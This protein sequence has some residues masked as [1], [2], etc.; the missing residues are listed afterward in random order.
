MAVLAYSDGG[1]GL[2]NLE[3]GKALRVL[4]KPHNSCASAVCFRDDSTFLVSEGSILS[5]WRIS[6]SLGIRLTVQDSEMF[7]SID[8]I[9]G[10]FVPRLFNFVSSSGKSGSHCL[11]PRFSECFG[12]GTGSG[13]L[14]GWAGTNGGFTASVEI[15]G[16]L[17]ACGFD[18]ADPSLLRFAVCVGSEL[19]VYSVNEN[20]SVSVIW[21]V[22]V[23][24]PC[25]HLCFMSS[26]VILGLG[27]DLRGWVVAAGGSA[28]IPEVV[29]PG[30]GVFIGGQYSFRLGSEV[31]LEVGLQTFGARMDQ[32]RE[33][34]DGSGFDR[35]IDLCRRVIGNDAIATIGLPT[36]ASQRAL[37]IERELA[38]LLQNETERR[39]NLV[40]N[41]SEAESVA[42][43]LIELNRELGMEDWIVGEGISIFGDHDRIPA[44][45]RRLVQFDVDASAFCYTAQFGELLLKH[46]DCDI[47]TFV[48]KLPRDV[49]S[50][51]SLLRFGLERCDEMLLCELLVGRGDLSGGLSILGNA[52]KTREICLLLLSRGDGADDEMET[53]I[54]WL[55]V[56]V[57][58]TFPRAE[59]ILSASPTEGTA[60]FEVVEQFI[61]RTSRP[62]NLERFV[63]VM[64]VVLLGRGAD[65]DLGRWLDGIVLSRH[66]RIGCGCAG[67]LVRRVFTPSGGDP[68]Y[69][70]S[71]LLHILSCD[72]PTEFSESILSLCESFGFR[73]AKLQI[74]LSSGKYETAIREL[75]EDVRSDVFEFSGQ[76]LCRPDP[77]A[78]TVRSAILLNASV[79]CARDC[80]GFAAFVRQHFFDRLEETVKSV[81]E[82][83]LRHRMIHE[84]L[85]AGVRPRLDGGTEVSF[86]GFLCEFFPS[87]A[88]TFVESHEGDLRDFLAPALRFEVLDCCAVIHQRVGNV[89]G[90]CESFRGFLEEE[91]SVFA[92]EGCESV[93]AVENFA[94]DF[95]R[96]FVRSHNGND[97]QRFAESAVR[98]FSIPFFALT[99]LKGDVDRSQRI[100]DVFGQIVSLALNAIPFADFLRLFVI[101]F[102]ELPFR[103][104]RACL[105]SVVND[106][107]YDLDQN[108]SM[109]LLYHADEQ[110]AHAKYIREMQSGIEGSSLNCSSCHRSLFGVSCMIQVF[111]CGHV[112]H[113]TDECLPKAVCPICNPEERLG[114]YIQAPIHAIPRSRFRR[115]LTR[116]ENVLSR[117]GDNPAPNP[118]SLADLELP[119]RN[120]FPQ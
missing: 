13:F 25:A 69:R 84:L 56:R 86:F 93:K 119:R 83:P 17:P 66:V 65:D 54:C 8:P 18:R 43:W 29:S 49:V 31:L 57:K 41:D 59:Q 52:G 118:E 60:L 75:A 116:F 98:S 35:A 110:N 19:S 46:A 34:V 48:L 33:S 88:R 74:Q 102:Q 32:F 5:L 20:R 106:Y 38:G 85:R 89:N 67:R 12:V 23:P 91:L 45:L 87:E 10:I 16:A 58:G 71:L 28:I 30:E 112:F 82:G 9:S 47:R 3:E 68:D 62:F 55:F 76:L 109:V 120:I 70:E 64:S 115:E 94:V 100:I 80:A 101:E 105:L 73:S 111:G 107:E 103:F 77:I 4:A 40:A 92:E 26:S 108:L 21:E 44:L 97:S 50:L 81:T 51:E 61:E 96:T 14:F 39:L 42:G 36:N 104:G 90:V 2:F 27:T 114:Q 72:I 1:L 24:R 22:S 6:R 79:L 15:S 37:V 117:K 95:G 113:Q 53:A 11:A 78:S 63:E 7:R 99:E